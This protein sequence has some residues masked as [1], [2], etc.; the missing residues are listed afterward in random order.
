V[1]LVSRLAAVCALALLVLASPA[2]A[3]PP[4]TWTRVHGAESSTLEVGVARTG[5]GVLNIL[6]S[7]DETVF[8]TQISANAKNVTGSHTVF[9]YGTSAGRH[10]ALLA[11]PGGGL[12]AFFAGLEDDIDDPH[13]VGLSTATSADGVSWAVQP[14]LAS[15]SEPAERCSCYVAH[16]GGTIWTNGTPMSVWSGTSGSHGYHVGT[17]DQTPDVRFADGIAATPNAATDSETGEVAVG[18]NDSDTGRVL[19]KFVQPTINPWFPPGPQINTPGGEAT[20]PLDRVAMTGRSN[21]AGGIF[22]AYLRGTNPNSAQPTVWRVGAPQAMKMTGREGRHVRVAMSVDKRLW[23][24]WAEGL[25]TGQHR[26]IF[27]RRSNKQATQFGATVKITPPKGTDAGNVYS[28]EGEG[29]AS[30]GMLDLVALIERG[31]DVVANWHQRIPPGI[32]LKVEVLGDGKVKFTTLDAGDPLATTVKFAGQTKQT[33]ADGVVTFTVKPGK[34]TARALR[35]GY[36]SP[37][38][39][40]RVK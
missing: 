27:A 2:A 29:T 32:T 22:V 20:E 18:W 12:R 9:V 19:I 15:S 36:V 25:Q 5:N 26:R 33:G 38:K 17:S 31:D 30:G 1:A 28:L 11:A 16:I 24:F 10:T 23:A 40:V 3:G 14:T 21:G 4:G 34:Y 35:D 7:R 8:N 37:K 6:W 39:I 13:H